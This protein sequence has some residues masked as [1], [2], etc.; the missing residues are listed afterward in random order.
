MPEFDTARLLYLVLLGGA[1]VASLFISQRKNIGKSLQQAGIWVLIFLG[2]IA[3]IGMWG[4]IRQT[5]RPQQTVFQESNRI[6]IPRAFD[7]HYYLSAKVNGVATDFVVDT[8]AT[9]IVLTRDAARAAGLELDELAYV[10]RAQT[11]N[12]EVRTA[13]VR[14]REI[15]VGPISD[16]N[17][18]AWVNE[19]E[20]DQ[21]LLGMSYLQRYRSIE[22]TGGKLILNR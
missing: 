15:S 6:E 1:L 10:G 3:V 8:G 13:P 18:R 5:V 16:S 2:V 14:L 22:I 12:G 11:A 17:L 9:D 20:M 21:S 19:G 4:D 7:G